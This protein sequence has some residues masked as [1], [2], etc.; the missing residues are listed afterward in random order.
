MC[1]VFCFFTG[2]IIFFLECLLAES[3]ALALIA[4]LDVMKGGEE[5]PT[6]EVGAEH[7]SGKVSVCCCGVYE[8]AYFYVFVAQMF[9]LGV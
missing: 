1:G 9:F 6:K 7:A 8:D 4:A 3:F 2:T 5:H